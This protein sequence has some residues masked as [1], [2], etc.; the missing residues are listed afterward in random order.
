M[1]ENKS[2]KVSIIIPVYN[3]EDHLEKCFDSIIK[4]INGDYEVILINDGSTDRSEMICKKYRDLDER[5][6]YIYQENAGV[7]IARNHGI[8]EARGEYIAFLDNDDLLSRHFVEAVHHYVQDA[9]D[10][11]FFQ[12][13]KIYTEAEAFKYDDRLLFTRKEKIK[14]FNDD[15][16]YLQMELFCPTSD[17]IKRSTIVFP[18]GKVYRRD[19][20]LDNRLFFDVEVR[21]CEDVYMNLK[22][23]EKAKKIIYIELPVY[24]YLHNIDSAGKGFDPNVVE[25]ETKNIAILDRYVSSK[26]RSRGYLRAYDNCRCFRYWSC[27]FSYFVHPDN[28]KS[29]KV[30]IQEMKGFEKKTD[31][32]RA[33]KTLPWIRHVM[34]PKE[35]IFL[36]ALKFHL[37]W[38][39]LTVARWKMKNSRR[40]WRIFCSE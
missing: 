20:L 32:R 22:V 18:W 13:R 15:T 1:F 31:M 3:A 19:F 14:I 29:T 23:Y 5:V 6:R 10:V 17:D 11:A 4:Q 9:P 39:M 37:Y 34:E 7:A 12:Y 38:P 26:E 28:N 8:E 25:I 24:Y 21:L 33:F 16:E 40:R 35:W 27:C 36:M 2:P 30:I